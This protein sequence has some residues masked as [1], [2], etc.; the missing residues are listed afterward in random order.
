MPRTEPATLAAFFERYA[1]ASQEEDPRALAGMYA[2]TFL[3][4]ISEAD[5]ADEMKR[6]GLMSRRRYHRL[7]KADKMSAP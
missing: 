6:Q 7:P 4:Y 5:Q 3:A 1:A 2:P